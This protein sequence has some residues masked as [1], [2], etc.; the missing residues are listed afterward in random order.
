M[1][2]RLRM[3]TSERQKLTNTVRMTRCS[4]TC[5]RWE[6]C[7]SCDPKK[8]LISRNG[9]NRRPKKSSVCSCRAHW[10]S[11]GAVG[12]C[13]Q[14]DRPEHRATPRSTHSFG[15]DCSTV[16]HAPGTGRSHSPVA[17]ARRPDEGRQR[18]GQASRHE[19]P[20]QTSRPPCQATIN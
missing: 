19:C 3:A 16:A 5:V 1:R 4:C 7:L 11:P 18:I 13:A 17:R 12:R 20:Y 15:N 9:P 8:R 14:Q 10:P 2:A 6:P